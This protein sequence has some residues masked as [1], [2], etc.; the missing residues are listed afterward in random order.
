MGA[1]RYWCENSFRAIRLLLWRSDSH[2]MAIFPH[3]L[4][5]L[6]ILLAVTT[7]VMLTLGISRTQ[8]LVTHM[9]SWCEAIFA[10]SRHP[11]RAGG[12]QTWLIIEVKT[13]PLWRT[14][15]RVRKPPGNCFMRH[16]T[17]Q[18]MGEY[19]LGPFLPPPGTHPGLEGVNAKNRSLSHNVWTIIQQVNI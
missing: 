15:S 6:V 7:T 16:I 17:S 4:A 10:L 12:G 14:S 1:N 8:T 5:S 9:G 13:R 3:F 19:D 11:S 18:Y 2:N